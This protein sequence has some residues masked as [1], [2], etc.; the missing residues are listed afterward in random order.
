MTVNTK[1]SK[2]NLKYFCFQNRS[3][4]SKKDIIVIEAKVC[5]TEIS[6]KMARGEIRRIGEP[7]EDV[8]GSPPCR[9]FKAKHNFAFV[10]RRH[11]QCDSEIAK[12][13]DAETNNPNFTSIV[14]HAL[15]KNGEGRGV[16]HGDFN[17]FG[18]EDTHVKG[19]I[20]GVTNAGTHHSPIRAC[21]PCNVKGHMEGRLV[22]QIIK[23]PL[24]GSTIYA[25]YAIQFE[26]SKKFNDT[27]AVGTLEGIIL[28]ECT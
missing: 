19:T 12:I 24:L 1:L 22:G 5:I 9:S 4:L 20:S 7:R 26:H 15:N 28:S 14:T 27:P 16:H 18:S 25:S 21:E 6:K 8:C 23:G 2:K 13:L 11:K 17:I 10:L 3:R